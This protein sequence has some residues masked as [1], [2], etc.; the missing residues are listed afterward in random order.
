MRSMGPAAVSPTDCPDIVEVDVMRF[1]VNRIEPKT[2]PAFI[3]GLGEIVESDGDD[4]AAK[5][6]R[7][8]TE[9]AVSARLLAERS[10]RTAADAPEEGGAPRT[11]AEVRATSARRRQH[12]SR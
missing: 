5:L 7:Y 2:V 8:L 1:I 12:R 10:W 9:W 4:V 11:M 3:A 6:D